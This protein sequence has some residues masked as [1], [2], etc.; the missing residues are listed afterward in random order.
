MLLVD[1]CAVQDFTGQAFSCSMRGIAI[2]WWVFVLKFLLSGWFL[3]ALSYQ[4]LLD[5]I[6]IY[7]SG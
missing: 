2:T 1:L 4:H 7:L 3:S 5:C 6:C